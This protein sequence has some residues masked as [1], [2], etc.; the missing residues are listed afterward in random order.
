MGIVM[1]RGLIIRSSQT[2]VHRYLK[3]LLKLT[4]DG[5]IDPSFVNHAPHVAR[6]RAEGYKIF[7]EKEDQCEK[8]VLKT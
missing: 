2:A 3:P 5:K 7:L 8:V 1:N 6:G 4:E